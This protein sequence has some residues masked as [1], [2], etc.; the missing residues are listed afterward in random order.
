LTYQF[1]PGLSFDFAA[2][3]MFTGP[4]LSHRYLPADYSA[5]APPDRR[6][7][8]VNPIAIVTSRV[9]LAF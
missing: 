9:R 7:I 3:Y 6:D 4:A 8:G 1:A 2:G 5:A